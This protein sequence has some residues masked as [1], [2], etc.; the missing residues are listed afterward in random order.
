MDVDLNKNGPLDS[1]VSYLF[2]PF[3]IDYFISTKKSSLVKF[4][5]MILLIIPHQHIITL[6]LIPFESINRRII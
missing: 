3:G 4:L 5:D 6:K 1:M 2:L